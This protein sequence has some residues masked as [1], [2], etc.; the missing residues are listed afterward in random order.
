MVSVHSSKTLRQVCSEK[1]SLKKKPTSLTNILKIK[2]D[3]RK[4][5]RF[6]KN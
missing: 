2:E 5:H 3:I 4:T 1:A 6:K